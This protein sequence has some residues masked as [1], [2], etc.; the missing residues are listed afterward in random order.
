MP[1]PVARGDLLKLNQFVSAGLVGAAVLCAPAAQAAYI[2]GSTSV[3]GFLQN[4]TTALG[5][6]TSLVSTLSGF[7][8]LSTAL[9]GSATGDLSA[10]GG[11]GLATD[12]NIGD[13]P[14]LLFSFDGFSFE[15]LDWGPVNATA[16]TC[17]NDQCSDGIGFS[18]TG[19]VTGNGFQATGFTMGWSAQGSCNEDQAMRGQCGPGATASWSA[20]ISATGR[21]V[22]EVSEP[23]SL[24]LVGLALTGLGF[25][26]R[27]KAWTPARLQQQPGRRATA[28]NAATR[29]ARPTR[30]G[31]NPGPAAVVR[32]TR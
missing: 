13:V 30:P 5:V 2:N 32:A 15:V 29:S 19:A 25:V 24:A 21:D 4:N 23:G 28:L 12:F 27:R 6:P 10:T 16:F 8:V 1:H 7:D 14:H 3:T 31:P 22:A 11:S 9:V 17:A 18:A 20:S 26:R